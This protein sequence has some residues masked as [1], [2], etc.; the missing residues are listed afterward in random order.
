MINWLS[1]TNVENTCISHQ[2]V[3]HS[4]PVAVQCRNEIHALYPTRF[5]TFT[6]KCILHKIAPLMRL[7]LIHVTILNLA[8][9]KQIV[10]SRLFLSS[11]SSGIIGFVGIFFF[12]IKILFTTMLSSHFLFAAKNIRGNKALLLFTENKFYFFVGILIFILTINSVF[13]E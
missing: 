13:G 4:K 2:Y 3:R 6:P 11:D 5:S 7:S 10:Y 1:I 8:W 12:A 9:Y